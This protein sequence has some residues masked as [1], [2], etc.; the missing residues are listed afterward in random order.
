[1]NII[2]IRNNNLNDNTLLYRR[3]PRQDNKREIERMPGDFLWKCDKPA[4]LASAIVRT[5]KTEHGAL[6]YLWTKKKR[7]SQNQER[8]RRNNGQAHAIRMSKHKS[9]LRN[10]TNQLLLL[11]C[12]K[13][14]LLIIM[15]FL[16]FCIGNHNKIFE[17]IMYK[18]QCVR[19]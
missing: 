16:A 17:K 15:R 2:R 8:T 18:N 14:K 10:S 5:W 19:S 11:I 13:I 12:F 6:N 1:M 4:P 3:N 7:T 9:L